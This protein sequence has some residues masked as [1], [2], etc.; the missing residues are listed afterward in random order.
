MVPASRGER[1]A[2][3]RA[4][5]PATTSCR[6]SSLAAPCRDRAVQMRPSIVASATQTQAEFGVRVASMG[7]VITVIGIMRDMPDGGVGS[8]QRMGPVRSA[9]ESLPDLATVWDPQ[10]DA[11][12]DQGTG[13]RHSVVPSV[14]RPGARLRGRGGGSEA[15]ARSRRQ[16]DLPPEVVFPCGWDARHGIEMVSMRQSGHAP[17]LRFVTAGSAESRRFVLRLPAKGKSNAG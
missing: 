1:M 6:A 15:A 12:E 16:P 5:N 9:G 11:R 3:G 13:A 17:L 2:I 7:Q 14:S 4:T 8:T 10:G